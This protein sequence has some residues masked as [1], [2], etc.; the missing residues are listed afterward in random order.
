M[1]VR[2]GRS[3]SRERRAPEEGDVLRPGPGGAGGR[4]NE[5]AAEAAFDGRES[6]IGHRQRM[7]GDFRG[8]RRL[9]HATWRRALGAGGWNCVCI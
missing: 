5:E 8:G 1:M 7:K 6:W 3:A 9:E 2:Q 4:F